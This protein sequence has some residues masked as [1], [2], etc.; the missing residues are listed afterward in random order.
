VI[1]ICFESVARIR[2]AIT[3]PAAR[4]SSRAS[5]GERWASSSMRRPRK[6]QTTHGV[7]ASTLAMR[8]VSPKRPGSPTTAPARRIATLL[9]PGG[10]PVMKICMLPWARKYI[11]RSASPCL[12]RRSP[13]RIS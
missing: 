11:E 1:G 10:P 6:A 3:A 2:V 12:M 8:G 4:S 5:A 7:I 13:A 9:L